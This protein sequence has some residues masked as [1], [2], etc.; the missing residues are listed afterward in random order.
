MTVAY[1]K[2]RTRFGRPIGGFQA[3]QQRCA[4]MAANVLT[5]R[6]LA[7][8]AARRL[9]HDLPAALEVSLAKACAGE[10]YQEVSAVSLRPKTPL[11]SNSAPK[12]PGS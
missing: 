5:A 10:Q 7:Y 12:Q 2:A 8:A 3:V 11:L 6:L 4:D 1:A 9:S